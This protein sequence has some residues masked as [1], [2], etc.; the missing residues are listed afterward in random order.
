MGLQTVYVHKP[1]AQVFVSLLFRRLNHGTEIQTPR[2]ACQNIRVQLAQ[3]RLLSTNV[4]QSGQ[5]EGGIETLG[6]P[7]PEGPRDSSD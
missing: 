7:G 5:V 6:P 2:Y 3:Q 1:L 4:T